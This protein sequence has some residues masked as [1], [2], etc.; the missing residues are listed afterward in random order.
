MSDDNNWQLCSV[1]QLQKLSYFDLHITD[2]FIS[3]FKIQKLG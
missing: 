3:S 1:Y 2:L